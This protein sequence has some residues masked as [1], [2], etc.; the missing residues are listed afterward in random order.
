M[1]KASVSKTIA[2][3]R[4]DLQNELKFVKFYED[5]LHLFKD[6]ASRECVKKLVLESLVHASRFVRAL[7]KLQPK[8]KIKL[9]SK[10]TKKNALY[11]LGNAIREEK[12]A[13]EIY[14]Y[15]AKRI[16]DNSVKKVLLQIA[17]DEKRHQKIVKIL[18]KYM[19]T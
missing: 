12:G 14:K 2:L 10:L 18:K 11:T 4:R 9:P 15:Q 13:E 17:A 8:T 5:N 6:D 19:L 1:K 16:D 3:M 7:H